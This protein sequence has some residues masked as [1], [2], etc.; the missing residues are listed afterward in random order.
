MVCQSKPDGA[1]G[2]GRGRSPGA[3][4][5]D[6]FCDLTQKTVDV[7]HGV[8]RPSPRRRELD[9]AHLAIVRQVGPTQ[10]RDQ[11]VEEVVHLF[12]VVPG[13]KPGRAELGV[14]DPLDQVQVPGFHHYPLNNRLHEALR[15]IRYPWADAS[16][17][18]GGIPPQKTVANPASSARRPISSGDSQ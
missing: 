9:V 17:F 6:G 11:P 2:A 8:A 14:L 4:S 13:R 7:L 12:V 5:A 18:S 10:D 15:A 16:S 3:L 1:S